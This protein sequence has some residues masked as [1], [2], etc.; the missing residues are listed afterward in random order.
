MRFAVLALLLGCATEP[1]RCEQ[2]A[3]AAAQCHGMDRG[4]VLAACNAASPDE[5]AALADAFAG[6]CR[7]GG[8][9]GG[10][11]K[12]DGIGETIFV[13]LCQPVL[14]TAYLVNDTRNPASAPLSATIKAKLR[15][16]FGTLVDR[17]QIH[18]AATLL[19]D[20][21]VL[22]VKDAFM[23]VGAQT[24][25]SEIYVAAPSSAPPLATLAHELVHARQA[26]RLGGLAQFYRAYCRAFYQSGLSYDANALEAEARAEEQRLGF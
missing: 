7:A 3:T 8:G 18:W 9:G 1:D 15:P 17:V 19:D 12:A 4:A 2:T 22:H 5:A 10:G 26:E 20:W 21:P 13:E 16:H 14:M 6:E 23:D 25:G 24:F 11:G